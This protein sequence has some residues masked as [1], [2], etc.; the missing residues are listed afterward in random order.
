MK[1][2]FSWLVDLLRP[3]HDNGLPENLRLPDNPY[4]YWTKGE[5]QRE[6]RLSVSQNM[7]FGVFQVLGRAYVSKAIKAWRP[8]ELL[9]MEDVSL[10]FFEVD[11][12][13]VKRI[14]VAPVHIQRLVEILCR[15]CRYHQDD[16][17]RESIEKKVTEYIKKMQ[18]VFQ[19]WPAEE[20]EPV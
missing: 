16:Q 6:A 5:M 1:R 19:T 10:C 9:L 12:R 17:S 13:I 3:W 7:E 4:W 20:D 8:A 14:F 18:D 11:D 2:F 15:Y